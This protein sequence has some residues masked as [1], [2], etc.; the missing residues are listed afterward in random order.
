VYYARK[1]VQ[2]RVA[3]TTLRTE[4]F[5]LSIIAKWVARHQDC[6]YAQDRVLGVLGLIDEEFLA[7]IG[8]AL[9]TY[10]GDYSSIAE[11]YTMFTEYLLTNIDAQDIS[12]WWWLNQ[13]FTYGRNEDLPS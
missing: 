4:P 7:Q 12:W 9:Q 2:D 10:M 5:Q 13:V 3:S 11:L 1:L 8:H 6:R